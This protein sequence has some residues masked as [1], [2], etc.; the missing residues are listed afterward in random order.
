MQF[1]PR[2][3]GEIDPSDRACPHCRFVQPAARFTGAGESP[4]A[5][6]DAGSNG[7]DRLLERVRRAT[8]GRFEIVRRVGYGGPAAVYVARDTRLDRRVAVKVMLPELGVSDGMTEKSLEDARQ[9]TRLIH[10]NIA[11][12][13]SVEELGDLVLFVMSEI[14]G[15]PLDRVVAC[16]P[17]N[18]VLDLSSQLLIRRVKPLPLPIVQSVVLQLAAG[19]EYAHGE[20]VVHRDIKPSTVM[21]TTKG[22]VVITDFGIATVTA[23]L[24]QAKSSLLMGAPT[25]MS[26][27][28]CQGHAVSG[29]SDQYSV[30]VI[31]YELLTGSPPFTGTV[32]EIQH[33]HV[34]LTPGSLLNRRPDIPKAIALGVMRMLAKKP[35]ARFG[36]MKA[37]ADAIGEGFDRSDPTPRRMLADGALAAV[38]ARESNEPAGLRGSTMAVENVGRPSD[39]IESSPREPYA[40]IVRDEQ[41]EFTPDDYPPAPP[42]SNVR[43]PRAVRAGTR[44]IIP[45]AAVGVAVVL[46][47]MFMRQRLREPAVNEFFSSPARAAIASAGF[48][49]GGVHVVQDFSKI[50]SGASSNVKDGRLFPDGD[51]TAATRNASWNVLTHNL[52]AHFELQYEGGDAG[53]GSGL[54]LGAG[55]PSGANQDRCYL[56]L[57]RET[58]PRTYQLVQRTDSGGQDIVEP[59][60]TPLLSGVDDRIDVV[61]IDGKMSVFINDIPVTSSRPLPFAL[62]GRFGV[63]VSPGE[64]YSFD[65][66]VVSGLTRQ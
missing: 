3:K 37:V 41:P 59:T 62:D 65:R 49:F 52:V 43:S 38:A 1:C 48:S 56:L 64:R 13:H 23:G 28:Q 51:S 50:S 29:A 57:V 8:E 66:I 24:P 54:Y 27:E 9:T 25:Y 2:C 32:A 40:P 7:R 21:I 55:D 45:L 17:T 53:R 22:D 61:A 10:P 6:T 46:G 36:S 19:L 30:G 20:G 42:P 16:L 26:P 12:E 34:S 60:P 11:T 39:V 33:A 35:E 58:T 5:F 31:A 47:L 44:R 18:I 14:V 4:G 15:A 63:Y